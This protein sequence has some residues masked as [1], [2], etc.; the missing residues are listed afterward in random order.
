MTTFL[1]IARSEQLAAALPFSGGLYAHAY[2]SPTEN[3]PV[4]MVWGGPSDT[5][6]TFS[7]D[8]ASQDFSNGLQA[9]GHFVVECE[10]TSGHTVPSALATWRGSSFKTIQKTFRPNHGAVRFHLNFPVIARYPKGTFQRSLAHH[11]ATAHCLARRQLSLYRL[12]TPLGSRQNRNEHQTA[13]SSISSSDM[14]QEYA[15]RHTHR[16]R[17]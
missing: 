16:V 17:G 8:V 6:G 5:Y 10:H 2:Q 14:A 7:F 12:H 13:R 4:M 11:L 1:I 3:I 9:D 15:S